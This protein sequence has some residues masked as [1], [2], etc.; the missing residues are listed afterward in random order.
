MSLKRPDA[1]F[2]LAGVNALLVRFGERLNPAMPGY[3]HGLRE[4]LLKHFPAIISQVVPAYTSILVEYDPRQCRMY[5][6]QL[7]IERE[8]DKVAFENTS[9]SARLVEVPVVY[10]GEYGP[11]LG[12]VAKACN[13]SEAE[14]IELHS[15]TLYSVYAQ[16]FA[17][18]FSYLAEL[19]QALRLPRRDTPREKVAAGSVAIAEQQTAVYP[20][21]SP[22]G[23]HVL[24]YSPMRW[25][26]PNAEKL[27]PLEVGDQVQFVQITARELEEWIKEH[28][29]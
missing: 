10:G 23:W 9:T 15:G 21:S 18:G 13:L 26:D 17:P 7:L 24:G 3:L 22:G 14:V 5:D 4:H 25:F 16:G 28:Q 20:L 29:S 11:D 6:L 27:T 8:L 2:E 12:A 19:P 1:T